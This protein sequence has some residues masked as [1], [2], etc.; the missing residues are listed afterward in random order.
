MTETYGNI[1][2]PSLRVEVD[3]GAP[4]MDNVDWRTALDFGTNESMLVWS[5]YDQSTGEILFQ[6]SEYTVGTD[7]STATFRHAFPMRNGNTYI[8]AQDFVISSA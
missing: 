2:A 7:G 4:D 5:I 6:S 8:I 3:D 1:R